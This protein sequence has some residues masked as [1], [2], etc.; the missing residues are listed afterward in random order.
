MCVYVC[1]RAYRNVYSSAE[2]REGKRSGAA[3]P[4]IFA[5]IRAAN[6]IPRSASVPQVSSEMPSNKELVS[7]ESH[8]AG[9]R[10]PARPGGERLLHGPLQQSTHASVRRT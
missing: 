1:M 6:P 10:S 4:T 2:L 7:Q 3:V 9:Q 8:E 5:L